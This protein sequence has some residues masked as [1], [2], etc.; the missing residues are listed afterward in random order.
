MKSLNEDKSISVA[1]NT[2]RRFLPNLQHALGDLADSLRPE[3]GPSFHRDIDFG[4]WQVLTLEHGPSCLAVIL[5]T[6]TLTNVGDMK[7][8][9]AHLHAPGHRCWRQFI[10]LPQTR[11]RSPTQERGPHQVAQLLRRPAACRSA[12]R[13][14]A[15]A[16]CCRYS[17]MPVCAR[18]GM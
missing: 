17:L 2:D 1:A 12:T 9:R 6:S 10:P 16:F 8:R 13:W 15:S 4:D 18:S 11:L 5:T 14:Q 3:C 7:M